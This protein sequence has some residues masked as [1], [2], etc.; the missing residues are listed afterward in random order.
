LYHKPVGFPLEEANIPDEKES[1]RFTV[2]KA[3]IW[4]RVQGPFDPSIVRMQRAEISNFCLTVLIR[5][6]NLSPFQHSRIRFGYISPTKFENGLNAYCSV[7]RISTGT[8]SFTSTSAHNSP[9]NLIW[10]ITFPLAKLPRQVK[11]NVSAR[12][13]KLACA[14]N[15]DSLTDVTALKLFR[16]HA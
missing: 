7:S 14:R 9:K 13:G 6:P 4:Q 12:F 1:L 8:K 11:T 2:L 15:T 3:S 5:L 16:S 10:D